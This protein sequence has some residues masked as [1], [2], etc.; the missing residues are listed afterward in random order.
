[1]SK[2][3]HF[4]RKVDVIAKAAFAEYK[5]AEESYKSAKELRE[6]SAKG[7]AGIRD[8]AERTKAELRKLKCE[9]EFIQAE[10]GFNAAKAKFR[11]SLREISNIR[12]SLEKELERE[13]IADPTK[14]DHDTM[15]LLKSGILTPDE[16][17][18]LLEKS[19]EMENPT[20]SR[21]IAASAS[22][23]IEKVSKSCGENSEAAMK[24]RVIT[25]RGKAQG[26]KETLMAFDAIRDVYQRTVAN[27]RMIENWDSLVGA[28][29]E[30]F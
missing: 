20:M 2:Y 9:A 15:V 1:M 19:I 22:E 26:G 25:R 18:F 3:N 29:I 17:D 4:A 30:E 21:L 8:S 10:Q 11:E 6:S 16:Y 14:V 5:A 12:Q 13:Y 24:L 23:Q 7:G 27:P 28:A